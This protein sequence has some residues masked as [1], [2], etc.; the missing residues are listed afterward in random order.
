MRGILGTVYLIDG[1]VSEVGSWHQSAVVMLPSSDEKHGFFRSVVGRKAAV[2]YREIPGNLT[3]QI[4]AG[5]SPKETSGRQ[6]LLTPVSAATPFLC[7][8]R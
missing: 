7:G 8:P 3:M 4:R 2:K 1:V 6:N 5:E